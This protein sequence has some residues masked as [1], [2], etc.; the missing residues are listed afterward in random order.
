MKTKKMAANYQINEIVCMDYFRNE[1]SKT[2][3]QLP[4]IQYK[5]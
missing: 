2:F 5:T 4:L 1:I 3:D